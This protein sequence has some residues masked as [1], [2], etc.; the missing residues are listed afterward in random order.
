MGPERFEQAQQKRR[1]AA[2][3]RQY[4][5][6]LDE[7]DKRDLLAYAA[8]IEAEADRLERGDTE[9]DAPAPPARKPGAS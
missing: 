3:I 4:G 7:L 5:A 9:T 8:S 6:W 2:L 1:L